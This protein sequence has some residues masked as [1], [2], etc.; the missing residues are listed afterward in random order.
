MG[1]ISKE[2]LEMFKILLN[3]QQILRCTPMS[4]THL[5]HC[6]SW[7]C[8][9]GPW[10]GGRW[11]W[12]W[13]PRS[14]WLN[15]RGRWTASRCRRRGRSSFGPAWHW[16]S[17]RSRERSEIRRLAGRIRWRKWWRRGRCKGTSHQQPRCQISTVK[18]DWIITQSNQEQVSTITSKDDIKKSLISIY[19]EHTWFPSSDKWLDHKLIQPGRGYRWSHRPTQ[20]S[21]HFSKHN[22]PLNV[23]FVLNR[24]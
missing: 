18:Q 16:W 20:K 6:W 15:R 5:L 3:K 7:K 8:P 14:R 24:F 11:A 2:I 17:S 9:F 19:F 12:G 1:I 10:A 23:W 13:R 4:A 22:F 21:T